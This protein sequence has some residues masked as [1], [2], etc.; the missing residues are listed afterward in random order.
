MTGTLA[1][2]LHHGLTL[3]LGA[4]PGVKG[5][6]LA[7]V[8]RYPSEMAQNFWTAIAAFTVCFIVTIAASLATP[9]RAESELAGLVY[10][11]TDRPR[12]DRLAWYARPAILGAM[13]LAGVAM[14]NL[15]FF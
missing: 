12:D 4:A 8:S 15:I 13:V 14:L 10:G 7:V 1:A 6:W 2:A 5:G 11:L 9:P 3:P